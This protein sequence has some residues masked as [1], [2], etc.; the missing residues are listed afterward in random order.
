MAHWEKKGTLLDSFGYLSQLKRKQEEKEK[1]TEFELLGQYHVLLPFSLLWLGIVRLSYFW[2]VV[3]ASHSGIQSYKS[4]LA[5][6][7]LQ[8]KCCEKYTYDRRF[9]DQIPIQKT[10]SKSQSLQSEIKDQVSNTRISER[11]QTKDQRPVATT[12]ALP[13]SHKRH[14]LSTKIRDPTANEVRD[15]KAAEAREDMESSSCSKSYYQKLL[16]HKKILMFNLQILEV[17]PCSGWKWTSPKR[18]LE[19]ASF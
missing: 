4:S 1:H 7:V 9:T 15:A 13:V 3:L 6:C 16:H 11:L 14:S 5:G 2:A 17:V 12:V 19:V 18:L 10:K 8:G